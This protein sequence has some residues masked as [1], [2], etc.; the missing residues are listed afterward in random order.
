MGEPKLLCAF[1]V[2]LATLQFIMMSIFGIGIHQCPEGVEL[3]IGGA[4]LPKKTFPVYSNGF[5]LISF[6]IAYA[7]NEALY[8]TGCSLSLSLNG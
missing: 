5:R 1:G 7:I 6:R 2:P 3:S 4:K 8:T